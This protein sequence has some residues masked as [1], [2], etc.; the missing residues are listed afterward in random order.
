MIVFTPFASGPITYASR[1]RRGARRVSRA[2]AG[3]ADAGFHAG[4]PW[5]GGC[6][7]TIGGGGGAHLRRRKRDLEVSVVI[8]LGGVPPTH[9]AHHCGVPHSSRRARRG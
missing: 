2:R 9:L 5:A 6:V 1:T 8:E 3:G 7:T 4:E